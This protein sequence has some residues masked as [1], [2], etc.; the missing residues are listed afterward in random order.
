MIAF[1]CSLVSART[2]IAGTTVSDSPPGIFTRGSS[3]HGQNEEFLYKCSPF[4]NAVVCVTS[5]GKETARIPV[6]GE[7]V[8][9]TATADGRHLLVANRLPGGRADRE[10]VTAVVSVIDTQ[11]R[12]VIKEIQLPNGST[13]LQDICLSPDGR[14]AAVTHIVASFNRASTDV[15]LGWLNANALTLIDTATLT[16]FGSV[17]LD[18]PGKGA[19]NPWGV[20]WSEDGQTLA[21]ALSG[22][23]EVALLDFPKLVAALQEAK[24][25]GRHSNRSMLRPMPNY[26]GME[27]RLPFMITGCRRIKLPESD[28][29]P[30]SVHVSDGTV[31]TTNY[32]SDTVTAIDI[33]T[34]NARSISTAPRS[35]QART[36]AN[37]LVRKG[38]RYFYDAT[39]C[40]QGWQSCASCH[41]NGRVDGVNWDLPNDGIGNPKNTKSLVLAHRTPPSMSLGVR[42]SAETAVRAGIKHILFTK[43][44]EDVIAA[45]DAYVQSLKPEPSPYLEKGRLSKAAKRGQKVFKQA[46]CADCHPPGLYTDLQAYAVGTEAAH[47]KAGLEFDTPTLIELWRTSPYLH[48]GSAT[49]IKEV[50]TI[51]N[52]KDAHGTTSNLTPQQIDDLCAYV[53]S[54]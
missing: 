1:A 20:A 49:T 34:G 54:L 24:S 23:H 14:F 38:E 44:P 21:V 29:G 7:P 36:P 46:G 32:F 28:L 37:E 13:G 10:I 25:T 35:S 43:Q 26:E 4:E 41:P 12:R 9:L 39:I 15:R 31:Y 27:E 42:D 50:I 18:T 8:A 33:A 16:V 53:L 47:E 17:L 48:D 40:F 19:A 5:Q 22:I 11:E 2:V 3:V 51:R 30:R 52:P 6:S 45:L